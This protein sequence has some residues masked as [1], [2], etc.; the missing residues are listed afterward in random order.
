MEKKS[1]GGVISLFIILIVI[2]IIIIAMGNKKDLGK[3][4]IG[5]LK[6]T[7][8]I[9]N[10]DK[11]IMLLGQEFKYE[12]NFDITIQKKKIKFGR[13]YKFEKEGIYNI[14]FD[15]YNP[16]N[17]DYMFKNVLD[18]TNIIL[19]SNQN[20]KIISMKSTFENCQNLKGFS[21]SGYNTDEVKS[22]SKL[23]FKTDL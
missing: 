19:I 16:I 14:I 3:K 2:L 15:I 6:C 17:M 8:E 23:F 7:Y 9:K 1:Y 10:S 13:E 5:Q 21:I 11:P 12:S 22:M 20:A 4:S 18:L